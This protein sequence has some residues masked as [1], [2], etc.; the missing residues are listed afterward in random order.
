[1]SCIFQN[2]AITVPNEASV[3]FASL[4]KWGAETRSQT[5]QW[6]LQKKAAPAGA[7]FGFN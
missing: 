1:M 2:L 6:L 5:P 3:T 4:A 7:A